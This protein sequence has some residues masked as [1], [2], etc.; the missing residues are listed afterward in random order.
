MSAT[1][2]VNL[3]LAAIRERAQPAGAYD[4]IPAGGSTH[5]LAWILNSKPTDLARR[6]SMANGSNMPTRGGSNNI[7]NSDQRRRNGARDQTSPMSPL[8][9][10]RGTAQFD[11]ANGEMDCDDIADLIEICIRKFAGDPDQRQR[12]I[13]RLVTIHASVEHI[14]GGNGNGNFPAGT[15]NSSF[16]GT[17]ASD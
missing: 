15:Y 9:R 17:A 8:P 6:S 4:V 16:N 3:K 5:P 1:A 10:Y 11:Q 14:N 7:V 12:F 13:G 2:I